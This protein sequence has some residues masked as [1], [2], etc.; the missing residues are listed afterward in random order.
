M[1]IEGPVLRTR[2]RIGS[3]RPYVRWNFYLLWICL[4]LLLAVVVCAGLWVFGVVRFPGEPAAT[5]IRSEMPRELASKLL[6]VGLIDQAIEQYARY[7]NEGGLPPQAKADIAYTVGR[8]CADQGRYE[9]ALTWLYQVEMLDPDT[10]LK[11]E[12][13]PKIV[14]CLEHLGRF[15]SAQYTLDARSSIDKKDAKAFRGSKPVARIGKDV[16]TLEEVDRALDALP[17]WMRTP[18]QKPGKKEEFLKQYV[19]E[20]LLYRKAKRLEYDKDAQVRKQTDTA[21]RQIMIQKVLEK[22]V[23]DKV[24]I[25]DEDISLYYRANSDRYKE[26]EGVRVRMIR[27]AEGDKASVE[28]ALKEGKPFPDLAKQWS[29]DEQTRDKGGEFGG[30]IEKGTDPFG[31]ENPQTLW[32]VLEKC[33]KDEV[34]TSVQADKDFCFFQVI[35]RRPERQL[36]F[37]EVKDRVKQNLYQEKIEKAYQE[38]IQGALQGSEVQLLPENLQNTKQ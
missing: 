24:T 25:Q 26:K 20:E 14:S 32:E 3:P 5:Q 6:S 37:E 7:F 8:L 1:P 13:G 34:S 11:D 27:V 22:E 30:W 2:S 29:T 18:F 23:K 28:R 38:L 36:A 19:A 4:V 15:S 9:E 31:V 33:K 16:I 12:V 21:L 10:K 35:D 17:E